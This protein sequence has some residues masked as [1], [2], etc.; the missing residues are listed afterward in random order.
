MSALDTGET[1]ISYEQYAY[2]RPSL[3]PQRD[4]GGKFS[5]TQANLV[6]IPSEMQVSLKAL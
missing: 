4:A 3:V 5:L 1:N 6:L 2:T